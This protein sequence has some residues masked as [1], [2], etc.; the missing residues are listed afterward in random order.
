MPLERWISA[1]I[2]NE[3]DMSEQS[4]FTDHENGLDILE[5][6]SIESDQRLRVLE[7]EHHIL[8]QRMR[9]NTA[10]GREPPS[11]ADTSNEPSEPVPD[12]STRELAEEE[13]TAMVGAWEVA[14]FF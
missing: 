3:H 10:S 4:Y 2:S 13:P 1:A 8:M 14:R 12:P 11:A 6:D 7:E 9:L 5:D